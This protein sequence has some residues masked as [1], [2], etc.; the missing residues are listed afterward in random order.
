MHASV[1]CSVSAKFKPR[2][3]LASLRR[4]RSAAY[5][6]MQRLAFSSLLKLLPESCA[7]GP[8]QRLAST[9]NVP[10]GHHNSDLSSA[11][12]NIGLSRRRDITLRQD[13]KPYVDGKPA[14][15]ADVFKV[16]SCEVWEECMATHACSMGGLL[17]LHHGMPHSAGSL[18]KRTTI[19]QTC[20]RGCSG[21]GS[22]AA[23]HAS[24]QLLTC[25][26]KPCP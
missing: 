26:S 10:A 18:C 19:L 20:A 21:I 3:E 15:L 7:L 24:S 25:A 1:S 4:T 8:P 11:A 14:I 17:L 23:T 12:C 2:P 9:V 6:S 13:L 22:H 16:R 5:I